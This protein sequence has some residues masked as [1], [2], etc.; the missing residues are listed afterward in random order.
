MSKTKF[1]IVG[2]GVLA[3]SHALAIS[4]NPKA[5]LVAVADI[6]EEKGKELAEKFDIPD[7]Y[8]DYE[9]MLN[10]EDI[11]VVCVCVPSGLHE[12]IAVAAAQAGKHVFCEKPIEITLEKADNMIAAC[13][14]HNVKL[15]VAFQRRMLPVSI[16]AREALKEKKIGKLIMGNA[17]LKYYRSPEYY[18]SAGWRGTWEMDGGGALMNQ[19]VH[20]IDLIQSLAGD[21]DSV[22]AYADTLV[23]EIEVEDTAVALLK[24]KNGAYGVIEG[25]T[26][27]YP[28]RETRIELNGDRGTIV[29][30]DDGFETWKF[31]DS[32]EPFPNLEIDEPDYLKVNRHAVF[33]D[34]MIE[35]I[36]NDTDPIVT[37]EEARKSLQIILAIYESSKSGQEVKL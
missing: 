10:R 31:M 34:D 18:R 5:E 3:P 30:T 13:H 11:D 20:G 16:R 4:R 26:S 22:Y 9:K 28:G 7:V 12:P 23:R 2:A 14:K 27:I 6:V 15:G 25:A 33:I 19:G 17:Y 36:K 1:A 21:V 8:T 37:G 24:Y 29:F 35:A 32:E